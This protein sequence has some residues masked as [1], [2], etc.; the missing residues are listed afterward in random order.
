MSMW[1]NLSSHFNG[2]MTLAP[3][4]TVNGNILVRLLPFRLLLYRLLNISTSICSIVI[5]LPRFCLS[6][7][8][9]CTDIT[10]CTNTSISLWHKLLG[11][12]LQGTSTDIKWCTNS[13]IKI[14]AGTRQV[15]RQKDNSGEV[16]KRILFI[17][18]HL[19][20]GYDLESCKLVCMYVQPVVYFITH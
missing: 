14:F 7:L 8:K 9:Y 17:L 5:K 2:V 13:K 4:W 3:H 19:V 6:L 16:F 10:W 11:V 1:F 12:F 15:F 18:V 20:I